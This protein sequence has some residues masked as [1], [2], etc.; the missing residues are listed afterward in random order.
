MSELTER[1]NIV[2][3]T[4]ALSPDEAEGYHR[5]PL[6]DGTKLKAA[7]EKHAA[8][9]TIMHIQDLIDPKGRIVGLDL[10]TESPEETNAL[11]GAVHD[12]ARNIIGDDA[13]MEVCAMRGA[14][15]QAVYL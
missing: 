5:R 2:V 7:F 9:F 4:P 15:P 13:E 1:W 3:S 14:N 12:F 8:Q 10:Y 11:M 6:K